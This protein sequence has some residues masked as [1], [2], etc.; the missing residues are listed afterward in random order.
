MGR[1]FEYRK[2]AKEKRWGAMSRIFPKLGAKIT[3]AAK[4]GGDNP[5]TNAA[6]KVAIANAKAANVPKNVILSAIKRASSK[7]AGEL[8][9]IHYE[10]KCS[11]GV[12]MYI[13]CASDNINRTV[14]EVKNVANKNGGSIIPSGSLEFIFQ[15]KAVIVINDMPKEQKEELELELID[16]GL[17]DIKEEDGYLTIYAD[18]KYFG[19]L[20]EYLSQKNIQTKEASLRRI[21]D[22]NIELNEEQ[23]DEMMKLVDKLEEL[24]DVVQVNYN[25]D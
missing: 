2:A 1:A 4:M 8:K 12:L 25:F 16:Y 21:A 13:E 22:N 18:Y 10:C 11:Y 14:A 17:E 6:L 20:C 9:E 5:E 15:K 23:F 24:D 19:E 7:E 3:I